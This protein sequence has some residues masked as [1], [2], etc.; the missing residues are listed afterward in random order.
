MSLQDARILYTRLICQHCILPCGDRLQIQSPRKLQTLR[1][2][3]R[4]ATFLPA[5]S[6][7]TS[8]SG[9]CC[10]HTKREVPGSAEPGCS[11]LS[12]QSFCPCAARLGLVKLE[13]G[14]YTLVRFSAREPSDDSPSRNPCIT[15]STSAVSP[16]LHSHLKT[17]R[18]YIFTSQRVPTRTHAMLT[19]VL[20]RSCHLPEMQPICLQRQISA[21]LLLQQCNP[22]IW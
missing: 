8:A 20:L 5:L 9:Q 4:P 12:V 22:C 14:R 1:A 7:S 10:K 3:P 21:L 18:P 13:G 19:S 17:D 2:P 15:Q 11:L 16:C 6:M